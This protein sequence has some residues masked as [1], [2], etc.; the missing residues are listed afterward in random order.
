MNQYY[1]EEE[2]RGSS[3]DERSTFCPTDHST[4][5]IVRLQTPSATVMHSLSNVTIC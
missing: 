3:E 2:N 1:D 4:F 5:E